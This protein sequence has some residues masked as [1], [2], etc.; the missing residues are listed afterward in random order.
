MNMMKL[1][2][3]KFL[4]RALNDE[5]IIAIF[6]DGKHFAGNEIIIAVGVTITGEKIILGFVESG[7]ENQEVC[8]DFMQGLID[9]GLKIEDE[10]LFIID[11][12]KGLYNGIKT[13]LGEKA[14]IQRCQWHKRENGVS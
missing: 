2:L 4:K 3:K 8:K 14:L 10:I 5:D 9:R 1:T 13:V 6:I 11:G 7:T 12:S